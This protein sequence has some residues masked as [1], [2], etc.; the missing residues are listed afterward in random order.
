[1]FAAMRQRR[2]AR[3][4][5]LRLVR[6]LGRA[7]RRAGGRRPGRARDQADRVPHERRLAARP[8][9]DPRGRARQ[10][11]GLPRRA[12][13]A[14][15]RAREHRLGARAGGGGR[16][17]RL[18]PA[19]RSRRTP[20]RSSSCAARAT[21]CATTCTSAPATTTRRPR[22]ST[23]TSASS[24][25]TTQI[26][27]DVADMFN[28]L[29][30]YARPEQLPRACSSRRAHLRD[31]IIGEIER[32]DRRAARPASDARIR[33]E[34]ELAR[35]QALH[36]RALPRLAGGRAGRAQRARHLLPAAG[37][38]RRLGEHPRRLDR[39]PLPRALAHLRLRARR[40]RRPSSSAP[41][42]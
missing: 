34:D 13:G 18:R 32:D 10:A 14:L 29:T 2:P 6:D 16:A 12:Q 17:R 19:R 26:G 37:R 5:P 33:D 9:A 7:L 28:L 3:P 30:G 21:A 39:R 1:M 11:G 15:R 8:G 25:A 27:A 35:R 41:P 31:G 20:R 24:P 36:P 22:A 38:A 23:P 42:T 4:P 40:A